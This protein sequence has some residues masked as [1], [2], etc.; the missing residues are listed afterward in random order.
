MTITPLVI[1]FSIILMKC[2]ILLYSLFIFYTL[3]S[4]SQIQKNLMDIVWFVSFGG[5][6]FLWAGLS[7]NNFEL[8]KGGLFI[9]LILAFILLHQILIK[10]T[11][12][13]ELS[14]EKSDNR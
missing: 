6:L 4:Y 1:D 9:I 7:L 3:G 11:Q 2:T 8:I 12:I 5:C 14:N 10:K 13:K